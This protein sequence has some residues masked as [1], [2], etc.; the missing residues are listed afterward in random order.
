M[1]LPKTTDIGKIMHKLKSEGNRP[2]RQMV[3]I[4]LNQARKSGADIPSKSL[5]MK[6]RATGVTTK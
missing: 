6:A 1:T 4:A 2:H 5:A 3:A